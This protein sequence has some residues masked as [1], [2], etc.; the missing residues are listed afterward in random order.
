MNWKKY[1]PGTKAYEESP[2][3]NSSVV[4]VTMPA[5]KP[6]TEDDNSSKLAGKEPLYESISENPDEEEGYRR[7]S[8]SKGNKRT[9]IEKVWEEGPY[10]S[11]SVDDS[12]ST[13]PTENVL[14][15]TEDDIRN[16]VDFQEREGDPPANTLR[17]WL[18]G[19]IISMVIGAID[20]FFAF[21]FPS[22]AIS[23][24]VG[25]LVSYPI[26]I[27]WY[28]IM[29]NWK[30]SIGSK[31]T[32]ELNPDKFSPQEQA[33][34][35]LFCNTVYG[36]G[37][38]K[39]TQVEQIRFFKVDIGIGRFI[40]FDIVGYLI[41][42]GMAG[43]ALP[44]LVDREEL[45]WPSVLGPSALINAFHSGTKGKLSDLKAPKFKF[46][47]IAFMGSFIWYWISDLIFPF[48][49][50]LGAFPSWIRPKNKVLGQVFGVKNGLGL[51]PISF[52]WPTVSTISNPLTTPVWAAVM[53][54]ASFFFWAWVV[55]PGLYYQ[56]HWQ[57]AHMPLMSNKIFDKYGQNY[58]ATKVVNSKW[59]LDLEKYKKYSPVFLPVGFLM[60]LALSL[61][62]FTSV[63]TFFVWKFKS[64]VWGPLKN[65]S[66]K[67]AHYKPAYNK[68][69]LANYIL[70]MV[71]GLALGFVFVEAWD[72]DLQIDSGGFIVAIIIGMVLFLPVAL[73]E[74]RSS[75]LLNMNGILNVI[76][77]FWY[78]GKPM[79]TLYFLNFSF[80]LYQHAMHF[81][82]GA[83][84][85]YYIK[86]PPRLTMCVL[87]VS[88]IW[89]SLIVPSVTGY[90]LYHVGNV[91]TSDA[92][93]NMT[94][95][96]Q[97]TNFN[98]QIV[99]GLFGT[100]LFSNG[101]RYQFIMYFFLVGAGVS[102][103]V[104]FMQWWRP[105]S[106]FWSKVNP[107]LLM[108]GAEQIPTCT[109]LH[110]GAWFFLVIAF[111]GLIHKKLPH[112][113]RKY[114]LILAT[115]LDSGV[116]IAAII[117]YFAVS[118][119]GG[120]S[121]YKWWATEVASTSCDSKACPYKSSKTMKQPNGLW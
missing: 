46:F 97:Q 33:L 109:G 56:N 54:F 24:I 26:G 15:I 79:A 120:S 67:T 32:F 21:R 51:F 111:N 28:R 110:Y 58:K 35:Y 53:I 94:C 43:L 9:S 38:L 84:L 90:V 80:A 40:L 104:I 65:H 4:D 52:D 83:K 71:V 98:T 81:T 19:I 77:A 86:T 25:Q 101:G 11:S 27:I 121:H 91:C 117:V 59:E 20:T 112:W 69:F 16:I 100:H 106:Y 7:S 29:P 88:G 41:A 64:D 105:K 36:T 10:N 44:I 114:N 57:T 66:G 78:K 102:L 119:T 75:F 95:K 68:F 116:A 118:Y 18:L 92:H 76:G 8:E 103:I 60:K 30:F 6:T 74:S 42:W 48:I 82:Q 2:P 13:L 45:I 89:T 93:N 14:D 115:A 34:V 113:W 1:L 72:R 62:G 108:S 50:D 107:T 37:I 70:S 99:W 3:T 12:N 39:N 73:V 5:E 23:P 63:M 87:F 49:A 55:M 85:G 96:S 61:G 47:S 17:M 31:Y 22:I